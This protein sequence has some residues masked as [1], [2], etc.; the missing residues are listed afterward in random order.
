MS[1]K[2]SSFIVLGLIFA[3]T[4]QALSAAESNS[5]ET[6]L[7][8][9][10]RNTLLQLR[11]AET[12][13]AD[14]QAAQAASAREKKDL[15]AK[16]DALV[17]QGKS[18]RITADTTIGVL[19][20]KVSEQDGEITRLKAAVEKWEADYKQK[21]EVA[22]AT[23]AERAKLAEA[24]I[25]LERRIADQQTKNH[26][27]FKLGNEILTRYEKFGLGQAL[28]AREPFVGI[29]RVK[30]ETFVQDFQDKLSDQR[31]NP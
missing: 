9:A 28:T 4:L 12:E 16:V 29:T 7:R 8:E 3:V 6:R 5:G 10:L 24:K 25:T 23:E 15:T 27:L 11:T 30:L 14:L 18:D 20:T 21:D 19:K 2:L 1:R 26:A 31:I 13:R 22:R 17:K